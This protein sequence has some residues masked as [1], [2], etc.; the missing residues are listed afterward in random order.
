M[1]LKFKVHLLH[2]PDDSPEFPT[3]LFSVEKSKRP[4]CSSSSLLSSS[5]WKKK[6][7]LILLSR[8][9]FDPPTTHKCAIKYVSSK[10]QKVNHYFHLNRVR[11]CLKMTK[12]KLK[13]SGWISS[14]SLSYFVKE[15]TW[16]LSWT[17]FVEKKK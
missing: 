14:L 7:P 1:C 2:F 8:S 15:I 5:I 10:K 12:F 4:P 9:Y 6:I 3:A 16:R 17:I 13:T 11:V